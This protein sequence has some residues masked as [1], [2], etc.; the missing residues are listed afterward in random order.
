MVSKESV[1][2]AGCRARGDDG[3]VIFC[4]D[5]VA[6]RDVY[7]NGDSLSLLFFGLGT[8]LI[9]LPDVERSM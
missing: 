7:E 9:S 2:V 4:F 3:G 8:N 5:C 1:V 6:R